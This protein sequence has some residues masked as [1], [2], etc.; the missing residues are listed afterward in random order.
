MGT[1]QASSSG[2]QSSDQAPK[3]TPPSDHDSYN[4]TITSKVSSKERSCNVTK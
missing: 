3:C 2:A 1:L 4:V